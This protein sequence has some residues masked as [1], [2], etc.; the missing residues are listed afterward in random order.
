M[1]AGIL[2][3]YFFSLPEPYLAIAIISVTILGFLRPVFF[4]LALFFLASLNFSLRQLPSLPATE[5]PIRFEGYVIAE[6]IFGRNMRF[7]I[8]V[9]HLGASGRTFS[10]PGQFYFYSDELESHLGDKVA[11]TGF[12]PGNRASKTNNLGTVYGRIRFASQTAGNLFERLLFFP[13]R[14]YF[15]EIFEKIFPLEYAR[16]TTG[17]VIGGQSGLTENLRRVFA[18]AG[19]THILAVSGLHITYIVTILYLLLKIL[20]I[21]PR[22]SF[23]IAVIILLIYAGVTSFRPSVMRATL[24]GLFFGLAWAF[25]RKTS[26]IHI[27]TV[28]LIILLFFD[29]AIIF[30]VSAQLSYGAVYGILLLLPWFEKKFFYRTPARLN[31]LL[32]IP[33]AVSF[34]AQVFSSPLLIYYFNQLP[35]MALF[36]NLLIVPLSSLAVTLGF[37]IAACGTFSLWLAKVFGATLEMVL[38]IM[39]AITRFFGGQS[40]STIKFATPP[41]LLIALFYC[42]FAPK[43]IRSFALIAFLLL[44]NLG[45]WTR[46]I[47]PEGLR[48]LNFEDRNRLIILPNDQTIALVKK[49]TGRW[50]HFLAEQNVGPPDLIIMPG[51]MDNLSVLK[52]IPSAFQNKLTIEIGKELLVN[53]QRASLLVN[54]EYDAIHTNGF[55]V[56]YSRKE[57]SLWEKFL[58]EINIIRIRGLFRRPFITQL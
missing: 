3:Q 43:K 36:S 56:Y 8:R 11:V 53:Y 55:D 1:I 40:F 21:P 19:V 47:V 50:Q 42:T 17:L 41:I 32:L 20:R 35:T 38:S 58:D 7:L 10:Y 6:E 18:N 49:P 13:L 15:R 33:L 16:L 37:L 22:P 54:N 12:L 25:E 45:V 2:F 28:S 24:M 30:D 52:I 9:E 51:R 46:N 14:R 48:I 29:P 5:L 26:L 34:S 57:K 23:L 4:Y 27:T 39:I 44:C 31:N